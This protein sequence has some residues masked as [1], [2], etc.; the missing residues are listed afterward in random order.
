MED[1]SRPKKR[2]EKI[3]VFRGL[4]K[5]GERGCAITSEI[6]K[7]HNYYRCTKKRIPCSQKYV[8]EETLTEQISDILKKV[9]LSSKWKDKMIEILEK[10]QIETD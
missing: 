6:Q 3:Y 7:G 1:K 10:E 2:S 5:C 8:R 9:S 4:L